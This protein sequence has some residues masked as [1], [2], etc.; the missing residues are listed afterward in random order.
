MLAS[1]RDRQFIVLGSKGAMRPQRHH[2][3]NNWQR[4]NDSRQV[5]DSQGTV[6]EKEGT[7]EY[8]KR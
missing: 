4:N 2:A 8:R 6:V 3:D 7:G 1:G 5:S